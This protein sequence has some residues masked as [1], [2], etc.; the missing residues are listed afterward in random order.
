MSRNSGKDLFH[1]KFGHVV[2]I[3]VEV[4]MP[5]TWVFLASGCHV[6]RIIWFKRGGR[7]TEKIIDLMLL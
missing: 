1:G 2:D 6:A 3:A 7:K 4:Y 5:G